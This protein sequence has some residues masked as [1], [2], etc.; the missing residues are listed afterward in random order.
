MLFTETGDRLETHRSR[1]RVRKLTEPLQL[2]YVHTGVAQL[3]DGDYF[4]PP[5]NRVAR[6][7]A[8]GHGGQVLL[9]QATVA[10]LGDALPPDADRQRRLDPVAQASR[11]VAAGAGGQHDE[12]VGLGGEIQAFGRARHEKG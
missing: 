3:R 5:L 1:E 10:L 7:L 12:I 4:G 2:L 9:S 6:L 11:V 8:V